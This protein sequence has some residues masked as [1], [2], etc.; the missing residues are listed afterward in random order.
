MHDP[1]TVAHE[2]R[3][4]NWHLVTIWHVDPE[5]DGTDDSCGR[6]AIQGGITINNQLNHFISHNL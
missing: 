4:K 3:I 2:I 1:K 5:T 6:I